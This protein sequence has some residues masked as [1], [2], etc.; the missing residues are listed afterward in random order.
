[1]KFI[2]CIFCLTIPFLLIA[3]E[4]SDRILWSKKLLKWK[5]FK[6]T[7]DSVGKHAAS[8]AVTYSILERRFSIDSNGNIKLIIAAWFNPSKSWYNKDKI[9]INNSDRVLLHE[10]YHFDICELY[11]RKIRKF[12]ST[13]IFSDS[14][15]NFKRELPIL[16]NRFY[17]EYRS[18]QE[19]YDEEVKGN[20]T[21]FSEW[22]EAVDNE[23]K[24]LK[25]FTDT[26][27]VIKL[28]QPIS[29]VK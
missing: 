23:M 21:R 16:L 4:K 5:D 29:S 24:D 7:P 18:Q 28:K 27:I 17:V 9:N 26:S 6:G 15:A 14:L 12:F 2:L 13:T 11:A 20:S 22:M 19:R 25:K 3:Q 8:N 1:M 10:Q